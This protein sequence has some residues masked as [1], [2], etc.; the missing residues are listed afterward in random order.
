M[1]APLSLLL[2]Q[3]VPFLNVEVFPNE[4]GFNPCEPSVAVSRKNPNI[5]VAGCVID[6]AAVSTDGGKTWTRSKLKS[7]WGVYG[8]PAIISDALGNFYYLHLANPGPADRW[9]E[10]IVCQRMPVNSTE[11]GNPSGIGPNAPK[12]QD[13]AWPAAHPERPEVAVSWTQFDKYADKNPDKRSN[14]LFSRSIDSGA[15][16]TSPVRINEFSGDCLDSD[17]TPEGAVPAISPDGTISVV[18]AFDGKLFLDQSTDGGK[19]WRARDQVIASQ[20]GGWDIMVDGI[21][22]CNGMP[23]LQVDQSSGKNRGNLYVMYSE[24]ASEGDSDIMLIRST[25]GGKTWSK[26]LR[27]NQDPPGSQQFFPWLAVDQATGDLFAVYYDRRGCKGVDTNVTVAWS[28]DGGLTFKE[29]RVN[30]AVI[31][32]SPKGFFGDYNNISAHDGRIVPIWTEVKEGKTSV[33]VAPL[34]LKEL[35]K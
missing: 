32:M 28:T 5:V 30:Q 16:W 34:T 9:L 2:A 19:N 14:I 8:D 4:G 11:L 27:V 35:Q 15:T 21:G 26:P 6:K 22:R 17:N 24:E 29:H 25:D 12:N 18:W 23:I 7:P 20:K 3:T 1:F 10:C 33:W 31:D 13:K